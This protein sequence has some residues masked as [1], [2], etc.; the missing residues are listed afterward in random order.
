MRPTPHHPIPGAPGAVSFLPPFPFRIDQKYEAI[1]SLGAGGGG[2]AILARVGDKE[3]CV[4]LLSLHLIKNPEKTIR[5]FKREFQIL[6]KLDH[7]HIA[8]I[9]DFGYDA[10]LERYYYVCELIRGNNIFQASQ[11]LDLAALEKLIVQALQALHYMHTFSGAGIRHNDI[12]APN[13]LVTEAVDSKMPHLKLI[14]F[15]L[16]ALSP[17]QVTGGTA[18]YMSPEQIAQAFPKNANGTKL[19]KADHRTDLYAMGVLWYYCATGTNPFFVQG[20]PDSTMQRHF[21]GL[22]PPPSQLKPSLPQYWDSIILKLLAIQPKDRY[23]TTAE[24]IR[25][26]ALLSGQP[27]SVIPPAQRSFYIP[28]KEMVAHSSAWQETRGLWGKTLSSEKPQMLWLLGERGTGKSKLLDHLKGQIQSQEGRTLF[29]TATQASD[30]ETWQADLQQYQTDFSQPLAVAV[31]DIDLLEKTAA[32]PL[33]LSSLRDLTKAWE[34]AKE[35]NAQKKNPHLLIIFTGEKKIPW[36]GNLFEQTEVSLKPFSK[37]EI[38]QLLRMMAKKREASPPTPL[39]KKLYDHTD[40]NPFFVVSVLRTLAEK[41]LLFDDSGHWHPTLFGDLGI[42]FDRLAIPQ[43]LESALKE[44]VRRMPKQEQEILCWLAA[45]ESSPT[46]AEL[47]GVYPELSPSALQTLLQSGVIIKDERNRFCFKNSFLSRMI[48]QALPEKKRQSLH[49]VIAEHLES[50][51]STSAHQIA[52]HRA[53]GPKGKPQQEALQHL[54][55]FYEET[56]RWLALLECC[57]AAPHNSYWTLKRVFAFRKLNRLEEAIAFVKKELQSKKTPELWKALG[58]LH[59]QQGDY[60]TA[61]KHYEKALQETPEAPEL[62]NLIAKTL[63]DERRLP[64]AVEIYQQTRKHGK[65]ISNNDLGYALLSQQKLN[66]ATIVLKEDV[67]F[68]TEKEDRLKLARSYFLLGETLRGARQFDAA[69]TQ[70]HHCEQIARKGKDPN[71]LLRA[72]NGMG[73]TY[74]DRAEEKKS[75]QSYNQALRYFEQALAL[76][77][78]CKG[79]LNYLHAETAAIF[80]NIATIHYE[81]GNFNQARDQFQTVISVFGKRTE[82]RRIEWAYLCLAHF[83]MA[84]I[85]RQE[86]NWT[87]AESHLNEA[88]AIV[89]KTPGLEEHQFGIHLIYARLA[90]DRGQGGAKNMH[91]AQAQ[92]LMKEKKIPPT[93]LAQKMME[94]LTMPEDETS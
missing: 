71:L 50:R 3:V 52:F 19:P 63:L 10:N 20:S 92:H 90:K 84:D 78:H 6:K 14:D 30:L 32:F 93:P 7:P 40:G 87:T 64:E 94:E 83:M 60:K 44:N 48:Y 9:F 22:P 45:F 67:A 74:L 59:H 82:L 57:D 85:L 69:I 34:H 66:E 41:G 77:Q 68:F 42:D 38:E 13:I 1:R 35:W 37:K 5:K 28:E 76:C 24:V 15:G 21:G 4:K 36:E 2:E 73:A 23:Q 18:S 39:V 33:L 91:L 47:L 58:E 11:K 61:R 46:E 55:S 62:Q 72:Y 17:V 81:L 43:N 16:A 56:G 88:Q 12:K 86:K 79:D 89:N 8:A 49:Q 75:T 70:Y 25:D 65:D 27:H 31:E 54:A 26:L 29:L 51:P 80:I 53:R